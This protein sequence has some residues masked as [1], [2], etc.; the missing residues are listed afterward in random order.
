MH[1]QRLWQSLQSAGNLW[2]SIPE[3]CFACLEPYCR[4]YERIIHQSHNVSVLS[5]IWSVRQISPSRVRRQCVRCSKRSVWTS[6][7][8]MKL[9]SWKLVRIKRMWTSLSVDLHL[10]SHQDWEDHQKH[11]GSRRVKRVPASRNN[12]GRGIW[13]KATLSVPSGVMG[14]KKSF[15][16][17][18]RA[19]AAKRV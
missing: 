18:S 14:M 3:A 17:M 9:C 11:D 13:R 12:M 15:A 16:N 7:N 5:I 1:I 10:Q 2:G 4:S 6:P 19:Q 8:G